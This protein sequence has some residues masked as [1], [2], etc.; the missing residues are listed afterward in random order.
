MN[1]LHLF[2]NNASGYIEE[3]GVNIYLIFDFTDENEELLKKYNDV[4]NGTTKKIKEV[5]SDE[6]DYEKYNKKIKF[7]PDDNL[8]LNKPLIIFHN[9]TITTRS[10]FE[11]DGKLKMIQ[12][13]FLM[14]LCI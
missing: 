6:C 13:F 8:P 12:K 7:N 1:P 9:M 2:I 4:W 11:E 3:K 14:I 10:A 5:G